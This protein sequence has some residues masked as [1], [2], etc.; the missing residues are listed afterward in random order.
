MLNAHSICQQEFG[1]IIS[2]HR[3]GKFQFSFNPRKGQYKNNV[4]ATIIALI[5]H[6]SKG[7]AQSFNLKLQKCMNQ[8]IPD[9]QDSLFQR[10]WRGTRRSNCQH[11]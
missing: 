11:L 4:Q 10:K 5:S 1:N 6:A 7:Y 9:I 2:G 8:E 3:R